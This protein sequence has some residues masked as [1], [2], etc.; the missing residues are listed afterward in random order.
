MQYVNV[1]YIFLGAV[2]YSGSDSVIYERRRRGHEE[3]NALRAVGS[4]FL[5]ATAIGNTMALREV[6]D[7]GNR[8]RCQNSPKP[9][10]LAYL[11]NVHRY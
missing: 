9:N 3:S 7:S 10:L 8:G 5:K 6:G 4:E 1:C 2:G 11:P